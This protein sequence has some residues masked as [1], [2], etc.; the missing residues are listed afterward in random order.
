[1]EII[2]RQVLAQPVHHQRCMAKLKKHLLYLY[3]MFKKFEHMEN[4]MI[5]QPQI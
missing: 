1:M 2:Q 3:K 4:Y 5:V